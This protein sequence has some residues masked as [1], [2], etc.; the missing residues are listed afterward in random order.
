MS[1]EVSV[2]TPTY[3]RRKFIPILIEIYRNQTYPKEKWN[4]LLL[5]MEKIV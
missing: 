3:N 2:V 5:M 1:I 4:G